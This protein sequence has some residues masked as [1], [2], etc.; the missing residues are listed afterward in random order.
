MRHSVRART[1]LR[2]TDTRRAKWARDKYEALGPEVFVC[3]VCKV[4]SMVGSRKQ[5]GTRCVRRSESGAL[6]C[7]SFACQCLGIF[8]VIAWAFA[9]FSAKARGAILYCKRNRIRYGSKT[10]A[11]GEEGGLRLK[12]KQ[13]NI[14]KRMNYT[15]KQNSHYIY[16][17][18]RGSSHG[19]VSSVTK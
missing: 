16:F 1:G 18:T 15:S 11:K 12:R 4:G 19:E 9:S 8:P 5:K 3:R 2:R 13:E 6:D 10:E 17:N 7:L 14:L